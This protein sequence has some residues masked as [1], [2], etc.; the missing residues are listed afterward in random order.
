MH[1]FFHAY[2]T[3]QYLKSDFPD[4]HPAGTEIEELVSVTQRSSGSSCEA[5]YE[6]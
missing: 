2:L 4:G 6:A 5:E 1:L 3:I